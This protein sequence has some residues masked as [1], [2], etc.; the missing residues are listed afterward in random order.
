MVAAEAGRER[1]GSYNSSEAD[2]IVGI[3]CNF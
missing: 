2:E 3:A 1:S